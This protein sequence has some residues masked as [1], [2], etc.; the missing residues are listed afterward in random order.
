MPDL[1]IIRYWLPFRLNTKD[2]TIIG[3]TDNIIPHEK[4]FLDKQLTSYFINKC[5]G[6][7]V[8]SDQVKTDLLSFNES[9]PVVKKFHPVYDIFG[10]VIHSNEARAKLNFSE[11]EKVILFFGFIRKYKGLDILL[12]AMASPEVKKLGIKLVIAGEFYEDRE[13]YDDQIKKHG[14]KDQVIMSGQYVPKDA[15]KYYF[16]ASNLVVQPYRSATQSGVTQIA[17]HFGV[18]MVVTNTGGLPEMVE[19]GVAG[20]VCPPNAEKVADAILAYFTDES[21]QQKLQAGVVK[22]KELFSWHEMINGI[23][24]V[25]QMV[26]NNINVNN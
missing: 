16:G 3:L 13:P 17:Y 9:K 8:M 1:V 22:N 10:E 18:P 26:Q 12:D 11:N 24:E 2:T 19:H 21:L 4:R 6:F 5:D 25:H 20:M 7:V 15:V 23:F 14:L